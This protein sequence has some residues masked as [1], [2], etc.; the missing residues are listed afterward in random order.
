MKRTPLKRG[1]YQLKKTP[2]KKSVK[3][4]LRRTKT[5]RKR[6]ESV[7]SLKKLLDACFSR[8]IRL[9]DGGVCFTCGIKKP[10]SQMQNGHYVSRSHNNT[11]YDEQNC[12]CQCVGCNVFKHGNMDVYS[13]RLIEKYG[14][15][16][17][18]DLSRRKNVIKQFTIPELKHLIEV[19]SNV[20]T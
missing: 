2:F 19:Y 10:I 1:T 4:S 20:Q 7:S 17:L 6:H 11:R 15:D 8:Y 16:I 5:R 12:H 14:L 3:K 9:R 18:S 13:L